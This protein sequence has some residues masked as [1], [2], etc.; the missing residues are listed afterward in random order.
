[1]APP[2]GM[3]AY[4]WLQRVQIAA[5]FLL[6]SIDAG[7]KDSARRRA[8]FSLLMGPVDWTC[9]AALLALT[10]LALEDADVQAEVTP[11]LRSLLNAI[12]NPGQVCYAHALVYCYLH[13]P[14][15]DDPERG[16]LEQWVR[17]REA[18]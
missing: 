9:G 11:L 8:L 5:A 15:H 17:G 16:T 12:P 10:G 2:D 4:L 6:A 7:W 13:L 1:M 14:T 18:A 3:R